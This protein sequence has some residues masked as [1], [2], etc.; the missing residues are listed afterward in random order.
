MALDDAV[1]KIMSALGVSFVPAYE[2][3]KEFETRL[4]VLSAKVANTKLTVGAT[5][6]TQSANQALS[7]ITAQQ[8]MITQITAEGEAKRQAIASESAA[9]IAK[10]EAEAEYKRTQTQ[11]KQSQA[12]INQAR[13]E[14]AEKQTLIAA[15]RLEGVEIANKNMLANNLAA[16]K[17][18]N[19]QSVANLEVTETRK[20]AIVAESQAK[21]DAIQ[22]KGSISTAKAGV[23]DARSEAILMQAKANSAKVLATTEKTEAQRAAITAKGEAEVS[24]ITAKEAL[25]RQKTITEEARAE[26]LAVQKAN[27]QI[28]QSYMQ[29]RSQAFSERP[30]L[31]TRH[32][33]WFA[34]G[35]ILFEGFDLLKDG[36]VDVE[37]GMKGLQTVLPEIAHDQEV[38]NDAS[39]EAIDIMQKYGSSLDDTMTAARS[40]GRMYKEVE[41]V[42]GLVNNA[43]LLNV[44]D[45]VALEDAVKGNEV[46]L[47]TYGDAL[48][49]T[50]EVLAFSGHLMDSITNLS[51]NTLATG[52]DLVN[53]LQQTASAAKQ[54]DTDLD[55]LLGTGAAAIRATGLQ[56]QGGNIGR[57]LRTVFTQLSAPTKAVEEEINDIGVSLRDLDT[58]KLRSAYDIILDLSLAT[59]DAKLSQE[60]LNEALLKAASGKFQYNKL[61]ALVG[62]FD[63]IVKNTAMSL[64]SQGLTLE[65]AA[66]QLDTISRK[67][68]QVRATLIDLFSGVGDSGLRETI[69]DMLDVV[70]QFI[71]GL[72]NMD[73]AQINSALQIG[74]MV[75]AGRL[76]IGVFRGI[77]PMMTGLVS[78]VIKLGSALQTAATLTEALTLAISGLNIATKG[79]AGVISA[80]L[81]VGTLA[82]AASFMKEAYAAGEA[83]KKITELTAAQ[84]ANAAIVK[85]KVDYYTQETSFLQSMAEK[86]KQLT[87]AL[88]KGNLSEE[89]RATLQRQLTTIQE[90]VVMSLDEETKAK[91]DLNNITDATIAKIIE[92][93][94]TQKTVV[95][96]RAKLEL[97]DLQTTYRNTQEFIKYYQARIAVLRQ[98]AALKGDTAVASGF[99]SGT[100]NPDKPLQNSIYFQL[101]DAEQAIVENEQLAAYLLLKAQEAEKNVQAIADSLSA[102]GGHPGGGGS[103][104]GGDSKKTDAITEYL[105]ALAD[106]TDKFDL[107]NAQLEASLDAVNQKLSVAGAEYDYLNGKMES[108]VYTAEEWARAQQLITIKSA[109]LS[110]E[111]DK[112]AHNTNVYQDEIA[113][114]TPVL[115]EARAAYEEYN[116]AGDSDHAEEAAKAVSKLQGKIDDLSGSI[117]SNTQKLWENKSALDGLKTAAYDKYYQNL[118]KWMEHMKNLNQITIEQQHEYI[119]AL[120]LTKLSA[121]N[122]WSAQEKLY[123]AKLAVLQKEKDAIKKAYDAAMQAYEDEIEANERLIDSKKEQ[124]DAYRAGINS[125]IAA[126][127]ELMDLLDEEDESADRESQLQDH[128]ERIAELEEQLLYEQVRT[129]IDHQRNMDDIQK[130]M[131][132]ENRKWSEKQAQ[133]ARQDQKDAYQD[134]IDAL[135]KKADAYEDSVNE[136]IKVIENTNKAK[137][138]EMERYYN[139]IQDMLDSSSLEM[140]ASLSLTGD[141]AVAKVEDIMARIKTAIQ[142]GDLA[143]VSSLMSQLQSALGTASGSYDSYTGGN[144]STQ[145][146]QPSSNAVATF[147][148]GEYYLENGRSYASSR[149]IASKLGQSISWDGSMVTI[150]GKKFYP[151]KIDSSGLSYLG[152]NTVATALGYGVNWDQASGIVSILKQAHTGALVTRSGA[153]ELL[154]G[155]RVLSP[156]LTVSFDRLASILADSSFS[157]GSVTNNNIFGG[158]VDMSVVERKLD[159]LIAV[160][161]SKNMLFSGGP[162]VNIEHAGFED[163]ADMQVLGVQVR[164][165]IGARG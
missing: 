32:L 160:M 39:R 92:L 122:A 165:V 141:S 109:L 88:N 75:L 56:G 63:D 58:G 67:A 127:K 146:T 111:Q 21:I 23:Y 70:N 124:V 87:E 129:G 128:N 138:K 80:G 95:L 155:E 10:M 89:Q 29:A 62:Q 125:Q 90:A 158:N 86:H 71:M 64:N 37:T 110:Q 15:G 20:Q 98:Y 60:E 14:A 103:S 11:A 94:N 55:K 91:I 104:D 34:T 4:N 16:E 84:E 59:Q 52:T 12:R 150:G 126:I 57:A 73:K 66:Q 101:K 61:S 137:K 156:E 149:S 31:L 68:G 69:K 33:S 41:T 81:S 120:D 50:N 142:N 106:A 102:P 17:R 30:N 7:P 54:A 157:S 140:L 44:I 132:E 107:I 162:L 96:E 82:A 1:V 76:L 151:A 53:I 36:L 131:A 24:A 118:V 27:E 112:L 35:A 161:S 2:A 99:A 133:W 83:E 147:N 159:R 154:K 40:F 119:K 135:E 139:Q 100:F 9:K 45:Q 148:Q 65:M 77:L 116:E 5:P 8:A 121:E 28:K 123:N 97:A 38:Y 114:L 22:A 6:G 19:A 74:A 42:M 130:Q 18:K 145:P 93:L 136:E 51:H 43:T 152:I 3:M 49:S 78:G 134:Q 13:V 48:K 46:A 25:T 108:G 85:Q 72:N 163:K 115:A 117:A 26:V 153:A 143:A 113:A 79:L 47:S 144:G 164:D 105:Q